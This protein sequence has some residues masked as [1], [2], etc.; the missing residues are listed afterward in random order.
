METAG[1]T[2][3]GGALDFLI[4]RAALH[5]FLLDTLPMPPALS[6][7]SFTNLSILV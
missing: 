7:L 6:G 3:S 2:L 4:L 5:E 1:P